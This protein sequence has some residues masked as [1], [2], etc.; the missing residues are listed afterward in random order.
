MALFGDIK[1]K[2]PKKREKLIKCTRKTPAF[3]HGDI[4]VQIR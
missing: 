1:P 3:R 2:E 4:R